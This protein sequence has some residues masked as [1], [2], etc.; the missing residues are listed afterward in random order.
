MND[1]QALILEVIIREY[2]KT[3]VPVSS[4]ALVDNYDLDISS[5]TVRNEMAELERLGLIVQPHTSA[6]R[7]PTEAAYK[8]Y[9]SKLNEQKVS[10]REAKVLADR[11]PSPADNDFKKA[12]KDLAELSGLAVFWANDQ[13]NVYYTGLANLLSQPDFIDNDLLYDLSAVFDSLDEIVEAYFD[14]I[15]DQPLILIGSDG[16]F[17]NFCSSILVKYKNGEQAGALGIL[18]PLRMDYGRN[19]SLLNYIHNRL[20]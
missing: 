13:G 6:G 3:G 10:P 16:P 4:H 9:I 2:I 8:W 15:T 11:L 20:I 5:A 19:L 1:R 7:V 18:G 14:K 17:G 12:A